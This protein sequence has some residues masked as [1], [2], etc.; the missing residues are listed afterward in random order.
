M[1][2]PGHDLGQRGLAGAVLAQ[3]RVDLAGNQRE[4]DVTDGGDAAVFLDDAGHL[5]KR[6]HVAAP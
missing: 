1:H 2:D 4:I 3:Q 5:E 6:R